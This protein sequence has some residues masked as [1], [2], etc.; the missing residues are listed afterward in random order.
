[1]QSEAQARTSSRRVL[2][3]LSAYRDRGDQCAGVV[4]PARNNSGRV[5]SGFHGGRRRRIVKD[6]VWAAFLGLSV[7]KSA[8]RMFPERSAPDK[9]HAAIQPACDVALPWAG[10]TS[11][12]HQA[13]LAAFGKAS[14]CRVLL[15]D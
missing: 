6:I 7:E 9:K 1:V 15:G 2:P 3:D 10:A 14:G 12:E 8:A 5:S 13:G 4:R 11:S